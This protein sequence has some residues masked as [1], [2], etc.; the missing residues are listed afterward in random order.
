[1]AAPPVTVTRSDDGSLKISVAPELAN[2]FDAEA[3]QNC[4]KAV[5]AHCS[6]SPT[7]CL[8]GVLGK[9]VAARILTSVCGYKGPTY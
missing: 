8:E 7:S 4:L 3:L 2:L 9:D 6:R 1:M 5:L